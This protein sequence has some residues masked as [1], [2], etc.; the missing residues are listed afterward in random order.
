MSYKL[1]G[2]GVLVLSNRLDELSKVES[3]IFDCDGTLIDVSKSYYLAIKLTALMILK[4]MYGIYLK[5]GSDVNE[6]IDVLKMLGGFNNDWNTSSILIQ[7]VLLNVDSIEMIKEDLDEIRIDE[8]LRNVVDGES[9]PKHVKSSIE[10]MK[11]MVSK[12]AGK[13]L[14]MEDVE[15]ILDEEARKRGKLEHLK[16]LRAMLGPLTAYGAGILTTLFDEIYL[17]EE[18]IL[19]KYGSK[20]KYVSWRGAIENETF[21]IDEEI[22]KELSETAPKGLAIVTGRGRWE[23]EKALKQ[24]VKYFDMDA[25]IFVADAPENPEK[26]DPAGL[27]ECA[28]RLQAEKV[29]YV[30][31]SAE[32]LILVKKAAERGLD[33]L[34]AG[35][36]TNENSVN[37]F[38]ENEADAIIEEINKL[39]RILKRQEALWRPF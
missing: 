24:L 20:P 3:I 23:T 31:D 9:F 35:V 28:K 7:A 27:I 18:G 10:W 39:P 26:P 37:F 5:L 12:Y 22:L 1:L 11:N 30:G 2:E 21:F 25:S 13:Y 17:G 8:Y 34:F 16:R 15:S 38:M 4:E 6:L 36:L 33:A 32:D 19:K 14:K 29:L